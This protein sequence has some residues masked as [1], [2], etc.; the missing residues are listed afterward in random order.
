MNDET[1]YFL[2][3]S[4]LF[5][6]LITSPV[7]WAL[8]VKVLCIPNEL[9]GRTKLG[10]SEAVKKQVQDSIYETRRFDSAQS[11]MVSVSNCKNSYGQIN[12]TEM[13]CLGN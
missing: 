2:L 3:L 7:V 9:R 10:V 13:L 8:V 6:F 1:I 12:P 11:N 5:C 4:L